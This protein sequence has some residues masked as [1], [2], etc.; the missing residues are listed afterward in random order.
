MKT[1][2]IVAVLLCAVS[3]NAQTLK[4]SSAYPLEAHIIKVETRT[5]SNGTSG[6]YTDPNTG[7]VSGGGGGGTYTW[8]LMETIIGDKLYGLSVPGSVTLYGVPVQHRP[9]LE[10]GTYPAKRVKNGFE[11]QYIDNRGKVRHEV[12]HIESEEPAPV[13]ESNSVTTPHSEVSRESQPSVQAPESAAST[14][15]YAIATGNDL[16]ALCSTA[17]NSADHDFDSALCMGYIRGVQ[18]TL[19]ELSAGGVKSP[20]PLCVGASSPTTGQSKDVVVKFMRDNPAIRNQDA[21]VVVMGALSQAFRCKGSGK[22]P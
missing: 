21:A 2:T 16:L 18:D 10:I 4:T 7:A 17:Q 22:K 6:V 12:L 19:G 9:W 5:G 15:N 13:G 14:E 20:F 8:H 11:F 1:R 3:V